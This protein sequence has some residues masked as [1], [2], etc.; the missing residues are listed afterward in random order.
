MNNFT[1]FKTIN[2]QKHRKTFYHKAHEKINTISTI[3]RQKNISDYPY[4][5]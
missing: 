2:I 5:I 4:V 1:I 3:K